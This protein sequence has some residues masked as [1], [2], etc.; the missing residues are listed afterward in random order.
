MYTCSCEI[1]HVARNW[2]KKAS[3]MLLPL[4]LEFHTTM[5]NEEKCP[6]KTTSACVKWLDLMWKCCFWHQILGFW[7]LE[8]F[9]RPSKCCQVSTRPWLINRNL[10]SLLRTFWHFHFL[11]TLE[12][13][14]LSIE[15]SIFPHFLINQKHAL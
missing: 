12:T 11:E 1:S 7:I 9:R 13:L 14:S 15:F 5:Q 4:T 10:N 6:C 3:N 8:V 2:F